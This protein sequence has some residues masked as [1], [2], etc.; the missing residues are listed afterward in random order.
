[1]HC[2]DGRQY[3]PAFYY[4]APV[5]VPKFTGD[6]G[7][8]TYRGVTKDKIKIVHYT[9]NLGEAVE[10]L[11]R[12]QG[13]A[14]ERS[15]R[16]AFRRAVMNVINARYELY[17][18]KIEMVEWEGQ[19]AAV[20]P[21]YPC[22]RN[23]MRQMVQREKPFAVI[24]ATSLASPAFD[25]LS[26]LKVVNLGGWHFRDIFNQQRRPYHWD[27]TMG[28]TQ[29]VRHVGEWWCKRMHGGKARYAGETGNG[30]GQNP[31]SN[32]IRSRTRVLGV[33]STDDPENK[34]AINDL[35]AELSK[36]GATVAHEYY[37]AQDITT[38]EQQRDAAVD[39]MQESPEATTIMCFCDLVAP[40]FLYAECQD[41]GYYPE[42][43]IVGTGFMD[44]DAAAQAYDN[45]LPPQGH[46]FENAFGLSSIAAQERRE[47]NDANRVWKAGGNEGT[48]PTRY[49][50][51]TLHWNYYAMLAMMIQGAGP[52]LTPAT[53][54]AGAFRQPVR[55]AG[56]NNPFVQ[57]RSLNRGDYTWND[58]M[59]EVYWSPSKPS[60]FNG[61]NGTYIT[62][63]NNRRFNIGEYQ[64]GPYTIPEKPR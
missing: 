13:S 21:D 55:G 41:R 64:S 31:P 1:D 40:I 29:L 53:L 19:C 6:N 60:S 49:G 45:T 62:L 26:A 4:Y 48:I 30:E 7:G 35:K 46:Q 22:L 12:A 36:C 50:D 61:E 34:L 54:E 32:D 44:A 14:S 57:Q 56:V 20:P 16:D 47:S 28:G 24:W 10:A 18:R 9:G 25:E 15:D 23:E 8:A 37:Y 51:A 3:D 38:A 17:G 43:I 52:N 59:R 33:I 58:N 11:L 27:V 5:C 2:V 39:E 63:N 42:H